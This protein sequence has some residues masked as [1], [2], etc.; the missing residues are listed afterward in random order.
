MT[1]TIVDR[2]EVY[3]RHLT[4]QGYRPT[5][6]GTLIKFKAE[7]LTFYIT[8]DPEDEQFI[9]I[10]CPNVWSIETAAER[11]RALQAADMI[12]REIKVTKAFLRAD[13]ENV[14]VSLEEFLATPDAFRP[15]FDRAINALMGGVKSFR[16][17]ME[18]MRKP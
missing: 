5:V 2:V 6:D 3:M 14:W 10:L 17:E 12:T 13:G 4:D 8:V 18:T 16:A 1:T 15:T 7:G 11:E 9:Q